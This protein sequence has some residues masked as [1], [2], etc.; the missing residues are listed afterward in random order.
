MA[1][2]CG[3]RTLQLTSASAKTL[4]SRSPSASTASKFT[5]LASPI[6][7]TTASRLSSLHKRTYSRLPVELGGAL[8]L[9]PLHSV[10]ASALFTSLLSLNNQNWGCLSEG[11]ATTL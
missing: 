8:S 10:T 7:P 4:L 6:K 5:G 9:M 1:A 2:N 11:F 3:R